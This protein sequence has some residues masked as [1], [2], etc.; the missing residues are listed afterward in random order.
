MIIIVA[1]ALLLELV[2][3]VLAQ[4]PPDIYFNN[5]EFPDMRVLPSFEQPMTIINPG[6]MSTPANGG[7]CLGTPGSGVCTGFTYVNGRL[8]VGS[9][10]IV[11][12][13][14]NC[15]GNWCFRADLPAGGVGPEFSFRTGRAPGNVAQGC[16]TNVNTYPASCISYNLFFRFWMKWATNFT[17]APDESLNSNSCQGKLIYI[18]S[19][20]GTQWALTQPAPNPG[21]LG[22]IGY[23]AGDSVSPFITQATLY[24]FGSAANFGF[25]NQSWQDGQWHEFEVQTDTPNNWIRLWR[26]G[27][28]M[29][30]QANNGSGFVRNAGIDNNEWGM[31]INRNGF[32]FDN[33][34]TLAATSFWMDDLAVSTQRI[35]GGGGTPPTPP[36]PPTNLIVTIIA[37]LLA[38]ALFA[39]RVLTRTGV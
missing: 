1:V 14:A 38:I 9:R 11:N 16:T 22:V 15:R 17:L 24:W 31:Y 2:T 37:L 36:P 12:D 3:P 13:P 30:D 39:W 33:C 28:L 6:E 25:F 23:Y 18:Q 4:S 29:I 8:D 21:G 20:A 5:F 26:D 10:S 7:V 35:G 27:V 34:K 19:V 32:N